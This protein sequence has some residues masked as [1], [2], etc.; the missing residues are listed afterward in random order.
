MTYTPNYIPGKIVV[1]FRDED[2]L[3][4]DFEEQF[5]KNFRIQI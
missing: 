1:K 3:H 2:A 4:G 5:G